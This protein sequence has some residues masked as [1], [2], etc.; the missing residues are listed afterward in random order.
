MQLFFLKFSIV[1]LKI[2][3]AIISLSLIGLILLRVPEKSAGLASFANTS[4]LFGS[5]GQT[6]RT[7]DKVM[8]V[9]I[10]LYLALSFILDIIINSN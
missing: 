5:P 3:A 2:P 4:N 8:T 1:F 9:G 10:L 7:L 6:E